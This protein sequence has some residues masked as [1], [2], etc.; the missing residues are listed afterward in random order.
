MVREVEEIGVEK[1]HH[2]PVHVLGLLLVISV[3]A[4]CWTVVETGGTNVWICAGRTLDLKEEVHI[5]HMF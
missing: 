1:G 2:L 4:A 5:Q 3:R